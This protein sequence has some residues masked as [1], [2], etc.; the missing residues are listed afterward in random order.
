MT[1][2]RGDTG[3][4][5]LWRPLVGATLSQVV[6]GIVRPTISYAALDRGADALVVG[7]VAASFAVIPM[8]I[9]LPVGALAGRLR[10]IAAV[11]FISALLLLA[12]ALLATV[13]VDLPTLVLASA[14]LGTGNL[15]LLLGCQTWIARSAP[16]ADYSVGFGW[17]TAGMAAGQA[18][19]PLVAGLLIGA[20][21][22]TPGGISAA[23]LAAAVC[24]L[25]IAV[26]FVSR[27][28]R[29]YPEA[30]SEEKVGPTAMLRS[31]AIV[32]YIVLSAAV[33][34]AVDLVTAYLP[35]V[36]D[37]VGIP[38]VVIGA[39]LAVRGL[40][41]TVSR[42][43]LGA[44]SRRFSASALIAASAFGAA[45]SLLFVALLPLPPVLFVALAIG[46][47]F[48]GM[49]QP[50]TMTAVAVLL[51]ARARS[52]GLAFRLV[53]NRIAQTA[54]PVLAGAVAGAFG[55]TAIFLAQ[56]GVLVACGVWE[57]R[58]RENG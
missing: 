51:P 6:L 42:V 46:G 39:M 36:G 40:A 43:F 12:G 8:L 45:G 27:A 48:L 26:L 55:V 7:L 41:S 10:F 23:F 54:M 29:R 44:L 38:P 13:S 58:R 21:R 5:W 25:A 2:G 19:G 37:R 53:G 32:R 14:L 11:P 24:A 35:L 16:A 50:L 9:A 20:G 56:V 52:S 33:L 28:S 17:L 18:I 57:A 22:A 1:V 34:T 4:G 31:P 30:A 49:G 15:G 47:L 3:G